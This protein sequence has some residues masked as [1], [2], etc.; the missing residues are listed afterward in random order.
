MKHR[1]RSRH[2]DSF[3]IAHYTELEGSWFESLLCEGEKR[4]Q[5]QSRE[6]QG[7][8]DPADEATEHLWCPRRVTDVEVVGLHDGAPSAD[9]IETGSTKVPGRLGRG[10]TRT[11]CFRTAIR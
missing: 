8:H 7:D 11:R 1:H 6:Q 5:H 9:S 3:E 10:S 2:H 4:R